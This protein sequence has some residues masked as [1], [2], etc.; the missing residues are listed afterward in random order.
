[1]DIGFIS[2]VCEKHFNR[3]A[4]RTHQT[5]LFIVMLGIISYSW[6][7][8]LY[9]AFSPAGFNIKRVLLSAFF[10]ILLV[11]FLSSAVFRERLTARLATIPRGTIYLWVSVIVWGSLSSLQSAYPERGLLEVSLY[12][13]LLFSGLAISVSGISEK[14]LLYGVA[15]IGGAIGLYTF[16][17]GFRYILHLKYESDT[18]MYSIYQFSHQR[19]L[20][21]AQSW[22]IPLFALL[23]LCLSPVSVALRK[24]CWFPVIAMYFFMLV[25]GGRGLPLMLF[26]SLLLTFILFRNESRQL[27]VVNC[28]A[29][30][31]GATLY[32]ILIQLIP[33]LWGKGIEE[34][35]L[36]SRLGALDSGRFELWQAAWEMIKATPWFGVGPQHYIILMGHGPGSP[37]NILLQWACEWGLPA[38]AG[39]AMLLVWALVSYQKKL[40]ARLVAGVVS[41]F[42][43]KIQVAVFT[44]MITSGSYAL[45]S[46]VFITPMSQMLMVLVYGV[47]LNFYWQSTKA[48]G[49]LRPIERI[50]LGIL[51]GS[52]AMVYLVIV[53]SDFIMGCY[54]IYIPMEGTAPRFWLNG[55]FH[56][57]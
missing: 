25:S 40:K 13:L 44:A 48:K 51:A 29:F 39:M 1:M 45:I 46:G 38:A 57:R 22:L 37:H 54:P 20:N 55:G 43:G 36:L 9:Y 33:W 47:A 41:T 5:A 28:K 8:L 56:L 42:Q 16:G 6:S 27:V 14:G 31:A 7:G 52:L 53:Y 11:F 12:M 35:N 15:V 19:T 24:L 30:L 50:M 26:C 32:L 21:H 34:G 10:L 2:Q 3:F 18:W 49:T 17:Y 4:G 23:P